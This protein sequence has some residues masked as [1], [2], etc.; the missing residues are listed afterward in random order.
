MKL[1][2][3][4][5][6]LQKCGRLKGK[7]EFSCKLVIGCEGDSLRDSAGLEVRKGVPVTEMWG[8]GREPGSWCFRA[9]ARG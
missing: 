1:G 6:I 7:T 2:R 8:T 3:S 4:G 5:C 9:G